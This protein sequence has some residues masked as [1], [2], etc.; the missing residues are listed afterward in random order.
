MVFGGLGEA[1]VADFDAE[2]VEEQVG[3]L[4]V[5]VD[6]VAFAEV[7]KAFQNFLSRPSLTL[8]NSTASHCVRYDLLSRKAARLSPLQYSQ[9]M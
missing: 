5:P 3:R 4:D 6:N 8:K 7:V 2:V 1:E 9:R